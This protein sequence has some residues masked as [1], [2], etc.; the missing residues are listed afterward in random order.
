M[1][2]IGLAV[3]LTVGLA[4]A[5]LA[6]DA[7]KP[8]KVYRIGVLD[9]TPVALNGDNLDAFRQG[10][11]ELQYAEGL[12]RRRSLGLCL[13]NLPQLDHSP[14]LQLRHHARRDGSFVRAGVENL[15]RDAQPP[16]AP[17]LSSC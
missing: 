12:L 1:R 8:G 10:M 16:W 6:V 4:L 2:L 9:P 14:A 13:P 17:S 15:S 5:P 7:Q 3:I 11:R